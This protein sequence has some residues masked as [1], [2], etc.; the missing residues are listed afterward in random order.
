MFLAWM[1]IF[2]V[3]VTTLIGVAVSSRRGDQ[4]VP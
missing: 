4:A 1:L 2:T 3:I